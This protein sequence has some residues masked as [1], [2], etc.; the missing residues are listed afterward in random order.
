LT[1][2]KT[3]YVTHDAVAG[4]LDRPY[5]C[6]PQEAARVRCT[7]FVRGRAGQKHCHVYAPKAHESGSEGL[8]AAAPQPA[9]IVTVTVRTKVHR[10]VDLTGTSVR[11]RYRVR[12]RGRRRFGLYGVALTQ[13]AMGFVRQA[14]ERFGLLGAGTL[15]LDGCGWRW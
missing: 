5:A 11:R 4:T 7:A 15:G 12:P 13:G 8:P 10:R 3:R 9:P 1:S 2:D 6:L 14:L